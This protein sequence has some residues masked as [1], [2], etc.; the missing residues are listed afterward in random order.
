MYDHQ[1]PSATLKIAIFNNDH[2]KIHNHK[3]LQE[4]KE[5]GMVDHRFGNIGA[6]IF[7]DKGSC[8]QSESIK[9]QQDDSSYV[10]G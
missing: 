4:K 9:S 10:R 5:W 7:L 6:V 3:K 1:R 8:C 2:D